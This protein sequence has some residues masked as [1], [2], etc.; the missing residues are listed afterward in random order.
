MAQTFSFEPRRFNQALAR[1]RRSHMTKAE[2]KSVEA[3][4]DLEGF[5]KYLEAMNT[6]SMQQFV[7][8]MSALDL[9]R[10]VHALKQGAQGL[11]RKRLCALLSE[12][13]NRRLFVHAYGL[14]LADYGNTGLL[15]ACQA[16]RAYMLKTHPIEFQQSILSVLDPSAENFA[17]GLDKALIGSNMDLTSFI[18]TY[19][20]PA[21]HG[22]ARTLI[23]SFFSSCTQKDYEVNRRLF[24]DTLQN[25]ELDVASIAARYIMACGPQSYLKDI[26]E[27]VFERFGEPE[28][29]N[30]FWTELNPDVT[31][32][33][34]EW[35]RTHT[36]R[37]YLGSNKVKLNFWTR[38][39]LKLSTCFFEE[40][41]LLILRLPRKYVVVD[42]AEDPDGSYL[43]KAHFFEQQYKRYL[44]ERELGKLGWP[45]DRARAVF[46]RDA[47]INSIPADVFR[48]VYSG[49][50]RLY[51]MEIIE[52][53]ID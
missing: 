11:L 35:L 9:Y 31:N 26:N 49:V 45:I 25:P 14:L 38:Y 13:A 17:Q 5:L 16:M 40:D 44:S 3:D 52:D 43:Y 50:G 42:L 8:D 1:I 28:K 29:G 53:H 48:I 18:A 39:F 41:G 20:L 2:L 23:Q 10:I 51:T 19:D 47:Q 37:E 34:T 36:L 24:A 32:I 33:F 46:I 7:Q 15:A 27:A 6:A 22:L 30:T 4:S 21:D 12:G